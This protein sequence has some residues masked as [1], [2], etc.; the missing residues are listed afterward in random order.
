V[1][2][3]YDR[4]R[5]Y[6]WLNNLPLAQFYHV[7]YDFKTP[8]TVCGGLQDNN[9]WC[10]PSAVRS[11]SGIPSDDWFIIGG[12]DGFVALVDP[13]DPRIMY[14][15]S[16]NGRMSRVD[17]LTNERQSI[18]PEPAEGE[19]AY[20]WN[21]DTPLALSPHDPGTVFVAANRVF[22]S[23]DRG[24]SWKA[25]S[26]DLTGQAD[27]DEL[28][29]MGVYGKEI[30]IAKN[31]GVSE[32]P[33]LV[34]FAES[35]RKA[36]VYWAGS[37]DGLMHLSVDAGESWVNVTE[38]IPGLPKG[39]Y[40]SRLAPS[41]FDERAAY[42]TF[43]GH[44]LNDFGTYVYATSDFG[45][46]WRSLVSNL[47][48]GEVA[49]TISEDLRNPD[50]LYLGTET[51]LFATVDRGRRWTRVKAGLP[52]VPIYEITL[53]PRENDL[54]L[55]THGRG[56]WILDDLTPFQDYAKASGADFSFFDVPPA[57]QRNAAGDRMKE[58]EGDRQFLGRN[59]EPGAALTYYLKA[60]AKEVQIAVLDP[61]GNLVREI[62]GEAMKE[63]NAAGL[64]LVHWDLRLPPL[65]PVKGQPAGP[66]F[67]GPGLN[68][69]FVL[70][71]RYRARLTVEGK[72]VASTEVPVQGDPDITLSDADRLAWFETARE[73]HELARKANQTA[74]RVVDG[75]EHL[76]KAQEALKKGGGAA[77]SIQSTAEEL[78]K[79]WETL[80]K[81]F[82]VSGGPGFGDD[83][84]NLRGRI[85]QLRGAVMGATALPTE[86]QMR[87][88]AEL[89]AAL[90][91]AVEEVDLA[92]ARLR[93][94][95]REM[96]ASNLYPAELEKN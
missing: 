94:L 36:G 20:R 21:W 54:I 37:D 29:L 55:A 59:P 3:S 1:G 92:V 62:S 18:R 86:V 9:T 49:R 7:S 57:I 32:Y 14:S 65:P 2:I 50:V 60:K 47:P 17:R 8:Y 13:S 63:K 4:S 95:Y 81:R 66:S 15:E 26:P 83:R 16:Q 64:N 91:Q 42:A 27:R 24:R 41:R 71:G 61:A 89:R 46:S 70:P 75:H 93:T 85:N 68:G 30:A 12:G 23:P 45:K 78:S 34:S 53:H 69:P 80:R 19:P 51:G 88:L 87:L 25:I 74:N 79:Q 31:D 73:L 39:T 90:P 96:A 58:F 33:T 11:R 72:E 6:V 44:R 38:K 5:T 22:R 77:E 28:N 67:F 35:P 52:T 82:G 43:D 40:V 84:E 56:I 48:P 76:G 10:G